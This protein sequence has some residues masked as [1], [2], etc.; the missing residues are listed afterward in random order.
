M[1][2]AIM[3]GVGELK[4]YDRLLGLD[5]TPAKAAACGAVPVTVSELAA[6]TDV[7]IVAVKPYA[8]TGALRE[9]M[10]C[11]PN[12]RR[13]LVISVAAGVSVSALREA[14]GGR[15]AVVRC[16]PN[17]PAAVRMGAFG[18]CLDDPV[19]TPE[20]KA[21][22][23]ALFDALGQAVELP[24][25]M[26]PAFSALMG[27]GP[28]YIFYVI[29]AL[30]EAG[31]RMGFPRAKSIEMASYL[32]AGSAKLAMSPGAHPALLRE[33]VCSP[34]GSTIE[35]IASLDSKA[36]KSALVEAVC[37]AWSKEKTRG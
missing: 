4:A 36:V 35:G 30:A 6:Q 7:L 19:L 16:M 20:D 12:G 33:A 26:L 10:A 9:F 8:A 2:G 23:R 17:T 34:A 29:E 32:C 14:A 3:R 28:A 25:G 24:E 21:E 31:V 13:P 5:H 37:A 11:V 27:C 1:G 18:L 15:A 22:V